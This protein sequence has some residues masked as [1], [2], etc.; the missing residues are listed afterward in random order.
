SEIG[1]DIG[2]YFKRRNRDVSYKEIG[3]FISTPDRQFAELLEERK[4][5]HLERALHFVKL[6]GNK[7]D[8]AIDEFNKVIHLDPDNVQA[9]EHLT[10]LK[11]KK[12]EVSVKEKEPVIPTKERSRMSLLWLGIIP[13][14]GIIAFAV[15]LL[16]KREKEQISPPVSSGSLIIRSDPDRAEVYMDNKRLNSLTPLAIDSLDAGFHTVAMKKSGYQ[17]FLETIEL[18]AG[19]ITS[20]N[21]ELKKEAVVSKPE[22]ITPEPKIPVIK[23]KQPVVK[24]FAYLRINVDPWARIYI[25]NRHIET[26]PIAS[27]IKLLA[28]RHNV[29]LENPNFKVWK[30][31][32]AFR[33]KETRTLDVKLEPFDGFLKLTVEPWADVYIDGKYYETTPIA[34]PVKLSAGQ[35]TLKL[36]NPSFKQFEQVINIPPKKMLKK[37][38]VLTAK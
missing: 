29:R 8:N 16:R 7:I 32:I 34:R 12:K 27:P 20:L 3:T 10:R 28:G 36:I 38:V 31:T 14:I 6:G 21:V 2:G 26:T 22:S 13:L 35:H 23:K 37:H 9:K 30:K 5:K 1:K 33:P 11:V 15:F 4:N 25:D 19:K 24:E 18:K 17:A